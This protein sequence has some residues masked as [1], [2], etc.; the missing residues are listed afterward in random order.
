MSLPSSTCQ[1]PA[2]EDANTASCL[3]MFG[4]LLAS[5][6]VMVRCGCLGRVDHCTCKLTVRLLAFTCLQFHSEGSW[7]IADRS[8]SEALFKYLV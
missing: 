2:E 5:K 4:Y 6:V 8:T 7:D 3:V 1:T